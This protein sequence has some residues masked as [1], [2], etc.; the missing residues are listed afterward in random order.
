M[1]KTDKVLIISLLIVA[2]LSLWAQNNTNSPYTRFGYGELA[3]RSLGAGR[4]MGGVGFGLRSAKQINPLNP[5]SYS[6]IDSLTFLFDVG[7]IGQFS[8]YS[9]NNES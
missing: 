4:A 8:W 6:A 1:L 2:Q 3:N 5:A 9:D 7:V